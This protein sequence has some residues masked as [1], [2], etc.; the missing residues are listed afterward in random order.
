MA[1]LYLVN[2]EHSSW[3]P[4][5]YFH[6]FTGLQCP[7]CGSQR[8]IHSM[9]HLDVASAMAFNPFLVVS[10]PYLLS[11]MA[12]TWF[13]DKGKMEKLRHFCQHTCTIRIYLVL[14]LL[15]WVIRNLM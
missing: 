12:V 9:L 3:V 2:P 11:L 15:W 13:D 6:F 8:A 14:I 10:L 4:K 7:A 1:F 5:C